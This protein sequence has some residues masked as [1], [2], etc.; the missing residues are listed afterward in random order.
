MTTEAGHVV[1]KLGHMQD[2]PAL[3]AH[4]VQS[5]LGNADHVRMGALVKDNDTASEDART[6]C[7]GG[8]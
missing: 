8:I 5:V 4:G 1:K 3:F 7:Y 2:G 6:F